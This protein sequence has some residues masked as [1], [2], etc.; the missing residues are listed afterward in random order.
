V[1]PAGGSGNEAVFA[2]CDSFRPALL[3]LR[4]DEKDE[5][6]VEL[7]LHQIDQEDRLF[8]VRRAFT[9]IGEISMAPGRSVITLV[10]EDLA[11]SPE[12]VQQVL[13]AA[14]GLEPRLVLRGVA[15]PCVRCLVSEEMSGAALAALH[16]R[17]FAG[18][19]E[20]PVP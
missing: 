13:R 15:A 14:E 4:A 1:R 12:L 20:E 6:E 16:D 17:I 2:V 10:S 11:T 5:R 19:P 18:H 9:G 3:V 7:A 8:E